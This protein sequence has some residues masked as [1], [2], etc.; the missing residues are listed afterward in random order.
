MHLDFRVD[1]PPD[2]VVEIDIH[3]SSVAKLPIY[4][5]LGV[6]EIWRYDGYT[7]KICN[8]SAGSASMKAA[9]KSKFL[10]SR[11]REFLLLRR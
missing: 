3:H 11:H 7:L 10:L 2:I 4:A 9:V 5:A 6:P 8:C 1:P